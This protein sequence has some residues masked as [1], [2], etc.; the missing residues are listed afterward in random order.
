[1]DT[2]KFL[3]NQKITVMVQILPMIPYIQPPVGPIAHYRDAD[4]IPP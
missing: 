1:L 2:S 3:N 4:P